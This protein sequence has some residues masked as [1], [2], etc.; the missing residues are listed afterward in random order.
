MSNAIAWV[1]DLHAP[2]SVDDPHAALDT[3]LDRHLP[4]LAVFRR[5]DRD[6]VALPLA[7]VLPPTMLARLGAPGAPAALDDRLATRIAAAAPAD[8]ERLGALR[9]LLT[10]GLGGDLLGAWRA[11][12]ARPDLD[13]FTAPAADLHLPTVTDRALARAALRSAVATHRRCLGV[14]PAGLRPT[15]LGWS[16]RLDRAAADAGLSAVLVDARYV[17]G[18]HGPVRCPSHGRGER[19]R[20]FCRERRSRSGAERRR[21][22]LRSKGQ[23][24]AAAAVVVVVVVVVVVAAAPPPERTARG[25][26]APF[27]I[28]RS[29]RGRRRR[30]TRT[31][32]S[33]DEAAAEA[34][35]KGVS[36][37]RVP[38]VAAA[39]GVVFVG[40]ERCR[41]RLRRLLAAAT[42][43]AAPAPTAS[44]TLS[45]R[46]Q[47][48]DGGR[49]PVEDPDGGAPDGG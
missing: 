39:A 17:P 29:R 19:R 24:A 41:R 48:R 8:A 23:A 7:I 45:A 35:D 26:E 43:A 47:R 46:P 15:D 42:A 16:D 1:L 31:R 38:P 30:R 2:G 28:A 11:L 22:R 34:G 44:L 6:G 33:D 9:R 5:L 13:L 20:R 32:S 14:S 12:A 40:G 25:G 18:V 21:E 3:I 37:R 36:F 27:I 10:D 4:L 49:G